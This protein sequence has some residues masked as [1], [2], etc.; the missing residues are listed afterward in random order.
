MQTQ[1]FKIEGMRCASCEVL[2]EERLRSVPGVSGLRVS[3]VNRALEVD[4][5]GGLSVKLLESAIASDGYR[6]LPWEKSSS[7]VTG[8]SPKNYREAILFIG[9]VLAVYYGASALKIIPDNFGV[10][11]GM[12]LGAVFI[13]GLVAAVSTCIAVSGGLLLGIASR[14]SEAHPDLTGLQKFRPHFY[15]NLGRL[16][17]YGFFGGMIGALGQALSLSS[18]VNGIVIIVASLFMIVLGFQLLKIFPSLLRFMPRL[19]RFMRSEAAS[20]PASAFAA[21][22]ST[23]FLPCGFTQALQ[24][25]VLSSG[26]II[27]GASTMLVFALGTLP[28]LV[29]LGAIA[30]LV[31]G[32]V[33]QYFLKFAGAVVL[34][35]GLSNLG[36]GFSLSGLRTGLASLADSASPAAAPAAPIIGNVQTV[37]MKVVGLEYIPANFT[38]KK[39]VPVEWLIDGSGARGCARAIIAPQIGLSTYL[40]PTGQKRIVF[41]PQSAGFIAFSCSMGMTTPGAGF[42]V[43]N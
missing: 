18:R 29:S 4:S 2:V 39:G 22:A 28:A 3:F 33:Q 27:F 23:F 19:P 31:K 42:T 15:F 16:A 21:G 1:K 43:V 14:Y 8:F 35:V 40:N 26:G 41:T 6:L 17:S 36:N 37:R 34:L 13:L 11:D 12:S 30:S 9:L 24:L 32:A 25:Y 10:S 5:K 20:T 7:G 38:V